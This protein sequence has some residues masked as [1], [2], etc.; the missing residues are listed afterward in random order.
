MFSGVLNSSLITHVFGVRQVTSLEPDV[1]A[2]FI[3]LL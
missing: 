1:I 3:E 2:S